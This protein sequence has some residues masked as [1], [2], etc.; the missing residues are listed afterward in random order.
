M[1]KRIAALFATF[2]LWIVLFILQKPVFLLMYADSLAD[3]SPVIFHG[4]PLDLSV[5][6]YMTAVPALALTVSS[7]PFSCLHGERAARIFQYILLAWTAIASIIVALAFV[8]NLA[9]YGYWRFPLDA[10]PVFFIATSPA[11]A[12]ASIVWWQGLLGIGVTAFVAVGTFILFKK[13]Y[14]YFGKELFTAR[15]R[16]AGWLAMVLLTALLFLPI[17]GGVTVSAMNTGKAYFSEN[18]TLNHAAVNPVLSFMENIA[19]QEDFAHQYRFMNDGVAHATFQRFVRGKVPAGTRPVSVLRTDSL[20]HPDIYLIILESFS[21]TL[22]RIKGVTPHLNS[23]KRQGLY[24][25]HFYAN[26]FRTDRGLVAILMGYPAPATV[27]LMK[28]PRKT[29]TMPSLA[30][31]L[32]RAGYGL[33]YYYGGD[34]DFTNMRSFL[35]NQGFE[36]ITEDADFPVTERLSKWG[37]PDHLLFAKAKADLSA[38]AS[39][40]HRDINTRR[41][42]FTVIQTSSSHEPFDVP[43]H[44]LSD[45]ILNAFAYADASLGSFIGYLKASGRWNQS[46]VIIVPDHLGAWPRNADSFKTWRF[47]VPLIWTGGMIKHPMVVPVYGSQQDIAA[48]VLGQLGIN[49]QDMTFSKDLFS[50]AFHHSAFFMM[51]DGFGLIDDD[52]TVIYD[53]KLQRVRVDTGRLRGKNIKNG[54]ATAQVLFDDIARR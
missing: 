45:P 49:H 53:N 9:L 7:L 22:T 30:A 42:A 17:R 23:L 35:I 14:R 31:H 36:H 52:N 18:Q 20:P 40:G 24:F 32:K 26:S 48:T 27:S 15:P 21:D 6:G 47:H 46:L 16:K 38:Q 2:A 8:A 13:L 37:V 34:A 10:T 28:F 51:N 29:A 50:D 25:S 39:A 54:K 3:V 1:K 5:A 12:M 19:H 11:D 41:P 44:R 33:N 43:Y 4:L